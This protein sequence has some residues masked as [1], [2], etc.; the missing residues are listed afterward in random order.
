MHKSPPKMPEI[1]I[2]QNDKK[3]TVAGGSDIMDDYS[4]FITNRMR[5]RNGEEQERDTDMSALDVDG[6]CDQL[7]TDI[8]GLMLTDRTGRSSIAA[9]KRFQKLRETEK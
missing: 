3:I 6:L 9:A 2:K 8:D 4:D 7:K 1:K 5:E